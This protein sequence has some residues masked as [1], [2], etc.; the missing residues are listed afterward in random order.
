[1]Q[2]N[3]DSDMHTINLRD[4]LVIKMFLEKA[5]RTDKFILPV[6]RDSIIHL[7]TK[8]TN[9]INDIDI[10]KKQKDDQKQQL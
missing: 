4:V 10:M 8:L 2:N 6:E 7:H 9:I 3:N 5:M 1:M